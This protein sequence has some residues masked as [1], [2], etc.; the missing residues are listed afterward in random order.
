MITA[1]IIGS[2]E[3]VTEFLDIGVPVDSVC[4]ES[5]RRA[6]MQAANGLG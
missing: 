5:G 6:L 2:V 3:R 4:G 1:A